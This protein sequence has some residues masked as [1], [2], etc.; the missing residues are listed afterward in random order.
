[1]QIQE[2]L[3]TPIQPKINNYHNQKLTQEITLTELEN[4]VFQMEN[5]KSPGIDGLP[6]EFYKTQYELIKNDLLQLYNSILFRNE[7]IPTSMTRAIVTLIPK[8]D[9]KKLWKN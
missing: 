8:T 3:F 2:E 7:S 1:M 6:I 9:T 5:A 4:A